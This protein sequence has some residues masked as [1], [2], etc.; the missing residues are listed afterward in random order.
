MKKIFKSRIFAFILGGIILGSIGVYAGSQILAS[1]IS[2]RDGTVESALNDLYD[3]ASASC[4]KKTAIHS[5]AYD[6]IYYYDTNENKVVVA[7]TDS[8]GNSTADLSNLNNITLYSSVA[9]DINNSSLPYSKNFTDISTKNDLYLIPDNAL[10]WYGNFC[11][12]MPLGGTELAIESNG[13]TSIDANSGAYVIQSPSVDY[14]LLVATSSNGKYASGLGTREKISSDYSKSHLITKN[15]TGAWLSANSTK[16]IMGLDG[17]VGGSLSANSNSI[18]SLNP[19]GNYLHIHTDN[20]RT[21]QLVAWWI[22]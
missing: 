11:N 17:G 6:E 8:K 5:A 7:V 2:Y 14:N 18:Y 4:G 13:W 1:D 15:V 16:N 21:F 10:Y 3:K 19:N 12:D 22:E 9:K 20:N